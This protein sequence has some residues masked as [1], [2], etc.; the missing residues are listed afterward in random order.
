MNHKT[1]FFTPMQKRK[2]SSSICKKK[3]LFCH[4]KNISVLTDLQSGRN[5]Y[6]D[7]N[8]AIIIF[9]AL[10]MLI[11]TPVGLQIRQNK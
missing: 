10:Q 2:L 3:H 8:P 7:L 6:R 9:Y 1:P 4:V 5:E 11:L